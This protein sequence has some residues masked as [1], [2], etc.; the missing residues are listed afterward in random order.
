[1]S[2]EDIERIDDQGISAWDSHDADA[3]I[4]L[5]ADDF[6]LTD[7]T[8]PEP[9]R[10]KDGAKQYFNGWVTA[11]PDMRLKLINRVVGED[12]VAAEVEFMGTNTGPMV[13]AGNEIPPTNKA[14]TGRGTYFA[15]I[16]GGKVTEFNAHPDVAG[17]MMQLGFMPQM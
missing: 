2:N 7:W 10:T 8:M 12:A 1:M 4:D 3:W 15:R 6:V 5:L 13:M 11:F 16:R 17:M 14:V 9:I